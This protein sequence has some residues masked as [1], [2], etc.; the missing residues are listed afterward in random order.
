MYSDRILMP[1]SSTIFPAS[2]IW[3]SASTQADTQTVSACGALPFATIATLTSTTNAFILAFPCFVG[4]M[5][6]L[7]SPLFHRIDHQRNFLASSRCS[8]TDQRLEVLDENGRCR[9]RRNTK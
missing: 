9:L 1:S 5:Q 3:I 8:R 4:P 2:W 6:L 7:S